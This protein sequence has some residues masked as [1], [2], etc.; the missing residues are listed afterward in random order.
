[1]LSLSISIS[2]TLSFEDRKGRFSSAGLISG[3][4]INLSTLPLSIIM[5]ISDLNL[6]PMKLEINISIHSSISYKM[7]P[8]IR[9]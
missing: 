3:K 5:E 6:V 9:S 1:M 2:L 7:L 4:I 8:R